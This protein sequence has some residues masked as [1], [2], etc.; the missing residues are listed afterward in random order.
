MVDEIVRYRCS[1]CGRG[2]YTRRED[3]E[4][5]E[6]QPLSLAIP[7]GTIFSYVNDSGVEYT[8][9]R[10]VSRINPDGH[11]VDYVV[12]NISLAGDLVRLSGRDDFVRVSADGMFLSNGTMVPVGI[13]SDAESENL[14]RRYP[15]FKRCVERIVEISGRGKSK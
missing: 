13:L 1:K 11:S 12:R 2:D 7:S 8:V 9:N 5:C 14:F 15:E 10:G 4:S 6:A 3:A